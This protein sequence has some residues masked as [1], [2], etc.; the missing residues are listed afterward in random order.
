MGQQAIY[1][2]YSWSWHGHVQ[3]LMRKKIISIFE[4]LLSITGPNKSIYV[5]ISVVFKSSM[6]WMC[7]IH[8]R[9]CIE[10]ADINPL[11]KVW[12]FCE[13]L[14]IIYWLVHTYYENAIMYWTLINQKI[15]PKTSPPSETKVTI[16]A[17]LNQFVLIR[18]N[19]KR[20]G[21]ERKRRCRRNTLK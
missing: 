6:I 15:N 1:W 21:N 19:H 2:T 12:R 3:C 18:H 9:W 8:R 7:F 11:N 14:I 20:E 10:R 13:P 17:K 5:C 16:I 4:T